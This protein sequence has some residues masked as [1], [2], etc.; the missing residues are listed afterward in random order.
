MD[1]ENCER[2]GAEQFKQ[3]LLLTR[4]EPKLTTNDRHSLASLGP[5]GLGMCSAH[6]LSLVSYSPCA[7][8]LLLLHRASLQTHGGRA[9]L[10][11]RR[12]G[13]GTTALNYKLQDAKVTGMPTHLPDMELETIMRPARC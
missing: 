13:N 7:F 8:R 5:P 10:F 4:S 1:G 12:V 9:A 3:N 6:D 2:E 11:V